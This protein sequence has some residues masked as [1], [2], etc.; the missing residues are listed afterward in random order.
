LHMAQ[1]MPLPLTVSCFTKIRIGVTFLVPAHLGS[2]GKR[3]VKR[4]CVCI[5]TLTCSMWES[6]G[7][8]VNAKAQNYQPQVCD[9]CIFVTVAKIKKF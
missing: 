6:L 4:V 9:M 1:L 3:A 2:P 8:F 7:C 5:K